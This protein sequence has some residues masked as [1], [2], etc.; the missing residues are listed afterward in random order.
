LAV[1]VIALPPVVLTVAAAANVS[2]DRLSPRHLIFTLPLWVALVAVG[3]ARVAQ[4]VPRK[5][6]LAL[7]VAAVV[8]AALVPSAVSDPRTQ[9]TGEQHRLEPAATWLRQ[10]VS[11][12]D[13]LYPYSALFLAALPDAADARSYSREPVALKRALA[14]T[15]DVRNV[16]VSLPLPEGIAPETVRDLRRAGIDTHDFGSW[17]VLRDR[18]PFQSGRVALVSAARMLQRAG[19]AIAGT[20][21]A[22]SYLLQLRGAACRAL[23]GC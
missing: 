20:P 13:V 12:G 17:L 15:E 22:H 14:R 6:G 19:P 9:S 8:A 4:S 21:L 23:N 1:T 5:A 2:A 10:H 3:L 11:S 18:G 16:W 7:P